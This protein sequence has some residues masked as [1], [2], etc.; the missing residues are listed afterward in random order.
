MRLLDKLKR[1]YKKM[2]FQQNA[3][4]GK[5]FSVTS[6]ANCFNT[7]GKPESLT[8]GNNCEVC[9]IVSV[10]DKGIFSMGNFSE[11]RGNSVVGCV[12]YIKIGSYCIISNNVHIYDNNNHPTS[13]KMREEM[14][15]N[16]FYGDAWDWRHSKSAP[17]IIEDNVWIGERCTI[18]KG[19]RIGEGAIVACDSVVTHDVPPFSVAAGNPARIVKYIENDKR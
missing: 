4:V 6:S 15:K 18:L 14:C 9:G 2:R 7:T 17:V 5:N 16:G 12:N 10:K 19:V 3:V 11:I 1:R 13:P 8:I